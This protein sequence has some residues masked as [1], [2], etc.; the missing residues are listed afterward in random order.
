MSECFFWGETPQPLEV[1]T[2][3]SKTTACDRFQKTK[4]PSEFV[5][6]D[7]SHPLLI[8]K[9]AR[10]NGNHL[11]QFSGWKLK[12]YLNCHHPDRIPNCK[13]TDGFF[14]RNP[15]NVPLVLRI[16]IPMTWKVAN[17]HIVPRYSECILKIFSVVKVC[18]LQYEAI[19]Y[20][21]P[22][23]VRVSPTHFM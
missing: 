22:Y 14:Y 12:K 16:I 1:T 5:F 7:L 2:P 23:N 21:P 13:E 15:I 18:F 9:Y 10:Q 11:P 4:H 3:F 19:H 6:L 20:I 8:E 17:I